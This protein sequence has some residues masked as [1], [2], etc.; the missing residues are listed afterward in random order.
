M[1]SERGCILF[2]PSLHGA[3]AAT[4]S[5]MEAMAVVLASLAGLAVGGDLSEYLEC[6]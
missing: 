3:Q 4:L 5:Q 1:D 6:A 2:L